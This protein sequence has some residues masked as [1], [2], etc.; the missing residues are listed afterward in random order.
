M[1]AELS[2]RRVGVPASSPEVEEARQKILKACLAHKVPCGISANDAAEIQRRLG[3]GWLM[4][5][6]TEP[7]IR[8]ARARMAGR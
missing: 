4:I 6:S 3:E 8:E 5:R 2:C 1:S 7:A